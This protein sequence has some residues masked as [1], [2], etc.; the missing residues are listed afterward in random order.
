MAQGAEQGLIP[1]LVPAAKRGLFSGVKAVLEI[2]VPLIIISFTIG[3]WISHGQMS[4]AILAVM[5]LLAGS[6][7][8]T[9]FVPEKRLIPESIEQ[10]NW[11]PFLR[12]AGMAGLFTIIILALGQLVQ[13]AGAFSATL[14]SPDMIYLIMGAAGLLSMLCAVALG[15]WVSTQVGLGKEMVRK[16]PGFTWWIVNRLAFLVGVN[17]LASFT[18]YFLQA[19]LGFV[20]EKAAG[21]AANLTMYVGIFILL[22]TLPSGWLADRFGHKRLVALS[23]IV[24]AL[25]TLVALSTAILPVIYAGG[26]LIGIGG[27]LFYTANWAL[28][29]DLV[30][31]AEAGRYLGISNLAGAGAGAIGAYIGGPIADTVSRLAPQVPGVGYM[32]LFAIYGAL[33]LFSSLVLFKVNQPADS[34]SRDTAV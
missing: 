25:G 19:R 20:R 34:P 1:D 27:G 13:W 10:L 33:F 15:V 5:A 3:R 28:G 11:A 9:M 23:G 22:S 4:A 2:P 12:L 6:M 31:K 29:T 7:I 24:A 30:P 26:C 14:S 32:L 16:T 8:L 17:N 18:V 21:P